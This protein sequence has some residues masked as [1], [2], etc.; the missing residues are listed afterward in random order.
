MPVYDS[1]GNDLYDIV[2]DADG[3]NLAQVYDADGN[4]L[5]TS[6]YTLVSHDDDSTGTD[7]GYSLTSKENGKTY[8]LRLMV[9]MLGD[10]SYQ[11]MVY[12]RDNGLYYKF[13]ASTTVKVYDSSMTKINTIT[14]PSSAG[15]TNDGAYYNGNIYFPNH[16]ASIIN[17]W[18]VAGNTVSTIPITGISQ[19]ANGSTRNVDAI[20]EVLPNSG[21]FY[22]V[23]RDVYTDDLTHQSDD[24]LSIYE[25][26]LSTGR[27]VL[28]AE[29][30]WDCV[31]CQGST[32]YDH[33]LYVTCNTQTTGSA[34]NYTGITVKVIRTDTWSLIDELTVSG[35]FEPEGLDIIPVNDG[36]EI[37]M[38]MGRYQRMEQ[39]VRFTIPYTLLPVES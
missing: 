36:H 19:P 14:M 25:Y 20:C 1:N 9:N 38:G 35:V 17:V 29:L 4:P 33:I 3:N 27:A 18:N 34:S 10:G 2:Y 21:K 39:T 6:G 37:M 8:V 7:S 15:H 31:Y 32:C 24:K 13:D 30:S 16:D 23:C 28:L 26:T 5:I 12:D 22:L 11:S